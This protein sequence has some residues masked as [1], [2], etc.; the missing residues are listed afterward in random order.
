MSHVV[1]RL[2]K[3]NTGQST[4]PGKKNECEPSHIC[5]R[6]SRQ[7]GEGLL[8]ASE[9]LNEKTNLSFYFIMYVIA[10]VATVFHSDL[11]RCGVSFSVFNGRP[12]VNYK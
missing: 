11:W 4:A 6:Y 9:K 5:F 1:G 3:K 12:W 7:R 8:E 10:T 2:R